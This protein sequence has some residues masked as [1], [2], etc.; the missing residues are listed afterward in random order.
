MNGPLAHGFTGPLDR[1]CN[2][3]IPRASGP[4]DP[5][6]RSARPCLRTRLVFERASG[7]AAACVS[8]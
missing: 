5:D 1:A 2:R 8:D 4:L 6:Y 7:P 3:L